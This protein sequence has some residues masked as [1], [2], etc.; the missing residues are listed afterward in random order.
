M[1]FSSSLPPQKRTLYNQSRYALQAFF[2]Y[3][4][5]Y[6]FKL[7]PPEAASA[8]GG[9]IMELIG[10]WLGK[11]KSVVLP[12]LDMAFPEKTRTEKE[13]IMR[14][15]WN[16][17]GRVIAEYPH[18]AKIS[19]RVELIG[20]EHLDSVRI[21]GKPAIF[22]AGHIG[23]WEL[24]SAVARKGGVDMHVVY[25]KPNN[26]WVDGL[27]RRARDAGAAGHI[28]KGQSGARQIV[29]L[30]KKNGVVGMLLDQ[31]MNE[32]IPVPFFGYPA[33]TAQGAAL[34][35]RRF[36][37]PLY[38]LR[39]ERLRGTHFRMT[40]YPPLKTVATG[41]ADEEAAKTMH[42]INAILESWVRERPE[43]WLWMHRR[44]R[45]RE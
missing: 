8:L 40:I 35:S 43:Q 13:K 17:L 39:I 7:L 23:N 18:I 31:K 22:F 44:W 26:L 25:R 28:E 19:E 14:G 5:Y 27:L 3:L 34:F 41:N 4:A 16:N 20:Q 21:Q 1:M 9:A 30:L 12:Q 36:D 11:T 42:D 33:K 38:P 45:G 10:P 24:G 2:A 6:F 29:T 32:G 37:C 15:M